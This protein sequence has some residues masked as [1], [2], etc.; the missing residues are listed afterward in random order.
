MS[1]PFFL[2]DFPEQSA[3]GAVGPALVF[4]LVGLWL[5]LPLAAF[6]LTLSDAV[7]VSRNSGA[8][9]AEMEL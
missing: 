6:V 4:A 2:P 5:A 3:S 9:I 7:F 1:N 8:V